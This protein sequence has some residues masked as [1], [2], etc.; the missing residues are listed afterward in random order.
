[1][2]S[3]AHLI[4]IVPEQPE[5]W[6]KKIFLTFDNDWAHDDIIKDTVD[7]IEEFQV[8]ATF[9]VTDDI[10]QLERI[11][12]NS[13]LTL[14]IH[15]NFRPMLIGKGTSI[16]DE[17]DRCM[18]IVPEAISCRSHGVIQGGDIS[19]AFIK[20]GIRFESNESIP[21]QSGIKVKPYELNGPLIKLP[22]FW[23]DEHEWLYDRNSDMSILLSEHDFCVFDFHPIHVFLNSESSEQYESTRAIHKIP[24][25]LIK[26]RNPGYGTRNKL[27]ELLQLSKGK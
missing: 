2:Y 1:M 7:L 11:K 20:R 25:E 21:F 6:Q 8:C 12:R 23:A 10:P 14:G 26:H 16:H 18:Q 24:N 13:N 19:Q 5:T 9:F 27:I 22:Y 3:F 17:I 15:P 4:N